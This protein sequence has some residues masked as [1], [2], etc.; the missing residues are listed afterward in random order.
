MTP[1]TLTW[2]DILPA[3]PLARGVAVVNTHPR[4]GQTRGTWTRHQTGGAFV[5]H[6]E[7]HDHHKGRLEEWFQAYTRLD[8]DDPGGFGYALR[9]LILPLVYSR[10]NPTHTRAVTAA[11]SHVRP[12][13]RRWLESRTTDADRL[14]L[15]RAIAEVSR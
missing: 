9:F 2:I 14:A 7:A 15:A 6:V 4:N 1:E 13:A 3:L 5:V 11:E 12:L 8:L 10:L